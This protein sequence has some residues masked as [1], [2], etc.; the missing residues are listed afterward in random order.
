MLQVILDTIRTKLKPTSSLSADLEEDYSFPTHIVPTDLKPDIA[1][2]D[3]SKKVMT[4]VELTIPFET[5]FD[6]AVQR[7]EVKYEELIVEARLK[8]YDAALITLEVGS[9]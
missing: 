1:C 3:D 9:R 7:K 5:S 8:E 2:W 4:L 6:G